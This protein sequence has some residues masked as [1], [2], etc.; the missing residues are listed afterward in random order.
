[1]SAES[2]EHASA[3]FYVVILAALLVL[4]GLTV[5]VAFVDMGGNLA[6]TV[7]AMAIATVKASLVIY[8]FMH[9]KGGEQTNWVAIGTGLFLLALLI[10]FVTTEVF[11]RGW[12]GY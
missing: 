1:V 7:V 8:F 2:H 11:T 5:G 3:G 10:G 12:I 9:M 6:N 4:T